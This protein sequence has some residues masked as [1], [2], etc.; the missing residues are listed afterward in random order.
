MGD[1]I[2]AWESDFAGAIVI[3]DPIKPE[4]HYPKRSASG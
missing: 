4:M 1:F 2:P 3:D